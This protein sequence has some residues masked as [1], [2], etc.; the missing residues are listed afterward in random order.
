MEIHYLWI[1]K[2]KSLENAGINLSSRFIFEM[3]EIPIVDGIGVPRQLVIK[4]NPDYIPNF[5]EDPNI[6]NV[7]AIIGKNG[8]GKSTILEY[9]KSFLPKGLEA[10]MGED[11]IAYSLLDGQKDVFHLYIPSHYVLSLKDET[12]LFDRLNYD[13]RPLEFDGKVSDADFIFYSYFLNYK[14]DVTNWHGLI[15]ISTSALLVNE[16]NR[17]LQDN[18]TEGIKFSLLRKNSDLQNLRIS[19]IAMA[20][21]FLEDNLKQKLPFDHPEELVIEINLDDLSYFN[22]HKEQDDVKALFSK[23]VGLVERG[24][25]KQVVLNNL[26]LACLINFLIDQRKYASPKILSMLPQPVEQDTLKDFVFRFFRNVSEM[27]FEYN[28]HIVDVKRFKDL[29][30]AIEVFYSFIENLI[31]SGAIKLNRDN[32]RYMLLQISEKAYENFMKFKS[33]YYEVKGIDSFLDFDWRG[34]S[35]GEQSYLSLMARFHHVRNHSH[36]TLKKDLVILIDEG[37]AGFHPEWQRQFFDTT[38]NFLK[39]VFGGHR[40]QLIFTA[41]TPFLSS[42]LPKTNVLFLEKTD[43]N[44]SVY[45]SKENDRAQTFGANIHTLY[46]D[47]FYL[48]GILMGEY[49]KKRINKIIAYLNNPNEISVNQGYKDVIDIIGEPL[50]RHKLQ[51]MWNEK[52]SLDEELERLEERIKEIKEMKN[53]KDQ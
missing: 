11:I 8:A 7:T 33:Y 45:H 51:S 40:L 26:L 35:S 53:N 16:R 6:K 50:I 19:E 4:F 27:G 13:D 42:D 18:T 46:S 25:Q 34:L 23:V 39:R 2:Y 15:N 36:Y 1:K 43:G 48:D 52:F 32:S 49:A 20:V 5:F 21:Q 44:A 9:L 10:R 29:V 37:D 22:E 31:N 47:S 17:I 12:K 3:E 28:N 30:Q 14:E 38:L 24:G 41:N